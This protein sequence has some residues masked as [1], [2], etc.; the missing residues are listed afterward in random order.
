MSQPARALKAFLDDSGIAYTEHHLDMFA[1]EGKKPEILA[2]NPKGTVPFITY[3]EEKTLMIESVAIMRFLA[4]VE[5]EKAGKF[6]S[7]DAMQKYHIDKWCDF[8]HD[9]FRP[10]FVRQIAI[11]FGLMTEKRPAEEKDL[12]VI[13]KA[14]GM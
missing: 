6:Y 9:S 5:P 2:I 12:F 1:G 3:G 13:E 10:A 11:M 14:K 4:T 8:Y 7:G